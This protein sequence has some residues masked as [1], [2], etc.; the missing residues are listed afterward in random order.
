M[1]KQSNSPSQVRREK[2]CHFWYLHTVH[3][4]LSHRDLEERCAIHRREAAFSLIAYLTAPSSESVVASRGLH[5]H[6]AF[7]TRA[8]MHSNPIRRDKCIAEDTHAVMH[9]AIARSARK[10]L[11]IYL[12]KEMNR[13]RYDR[14]ERKS[15]CSAFLRSI[16]S[17]DWSVGYWSMDCLEKGAKQGMKIEVSL[18]RG[19]HVM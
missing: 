5:T 11:T 9:A 3:R 18:Q 7:N 1:T 8:G 10:V 15:D 4:I 6:V 17:V 13:C 12:W 2:S 19:N 14:V 16:L